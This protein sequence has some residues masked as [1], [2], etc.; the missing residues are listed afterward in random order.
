MN[1][2]RTVLTAA[3]ASGLVVGFSGQALADVYAGSSLQVSNLVIGI[4]G[5]TGGAGITGYTF[6]LDNTATLNGVSATTPGISTTCNSVGIPPCSNPPP[7]LNA[8]VANAPGSTLLR[9][10]NNFT[11]LGSA[12]AGQTFANSDSQITTSELVNGV[13]TSTVQISEAEI[14]GTG[15]GQSSTTVQSNTTFSFTFNVG[16]GGTFDLNFAAD[17]DLFVAV[18]TA[19]L[20]GALSQAN[21]GATVTLTNGAGQTVQWSPDGIAGGFTQCSGGLVCT[22]VNDSQSLN[23]SIG[24]TGGNPSSNCV[25][26]ARGGCIDTGF[27]LFGIHVTGLSGGSYSLTLNATSS[28]NVVQRVGAVPEPGVLALLGVGLVGAFAT[29]RRRRKTA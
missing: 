20:L 21:T 1:L 9:P 11:F 12:T 13:P 24:L 23:N 29:T 28:V 7:A 18:S 10:D 25:S 8:T 3:L 22:E 2:K 26:D 19:N 14:A 15:T 16:T 4:G 27:T 17:P 6:N 5:V